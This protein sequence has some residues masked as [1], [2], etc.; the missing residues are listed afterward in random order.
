MID[1]IENTSPLVWPSDDY[2][3]TPYEVYTSS[4]IF[5]QEQQ[6]IFDAPTWM[7]VGLECEFKKP[8]D[9]TTSFMGTTPIV[10]SLAPDGELYGFVN[11]CAHRGAKVVRELRGNAKFLKCLYHGWTYDNMGDLRA[12][13]LEN[14]ILGQGGYPDDFKTENHCLRKLKLDSIAGVIFGSL[15]LNAPPLLDY[16]GPGIVERIKTICHSP[17]KV[18]GYQRQTM[19]CNWKLFVENTRDMYHAPMLHAFIPQF[20][21]F[22]PAKQKN[23]LILENGGANQAFSTYEM[24]GV[25]AA[26]KGLIGKIA[27]PIIQKSMSSPAD[28]NR[29]KLIFEDPS[30]ARG[31]SELAG[32]LYI[33]IVSIFPATL[34]TIIGQ[35]FSIRQIRPIAPDKMETVYTWFQFESD[36]EEMH[37][38]RVKQSNLLGPA[39][40]VAMEDAEV[41]E[42]TQQMIAR[43]LESGSTFMEMGGRNVEET[44]SHGVTE[45]SIR[46]FWKTYCKYMDIPTSTD[47]V[48]AE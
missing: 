20:G 28:G 32:G 47:Q 37:D 38:R 40:Y 45:T 36:D 15:D 1:N 34:F 12:V 16:I 29:E 30:V 4:E 7:Y 35:T 17:M 11:K 43:G 33:N 22:N 2:T 25:K 41:M 46:G 31:T 42:S 27:A 44:G 3:R 39:G 10:I 24:E 13:P 5:A 23:E 19:N 6:K 18:W 9:Y 8:G 21:M 26:A 48:A 14:G